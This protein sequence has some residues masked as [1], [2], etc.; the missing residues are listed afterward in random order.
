MNNVRLRWRVA[1]FIHRTKLYNGNKKTT[2][3]KN[4]TSAADTG[5][6]GSL[7][8]ACLLARKH[9]TIFLINVHCCCISKCQINTAI[10]LTALAK[11]VIKSPF[12]SVS[13]L[14]FEPRG[15]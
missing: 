6:V 2:N 10:L 12:L 13:T 15:V 5:F 3:N 14:T 1:S 7:F 9:R 11:K 4:P 8:G